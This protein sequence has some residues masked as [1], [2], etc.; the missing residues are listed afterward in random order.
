[1]TSLQATIV[2]EK[3]VVSAHRTALDG[4][5][6]RRPSSILCLCKSTSSLPRLPLQPKDDPGQSATTLTRMRIDPQRDSKLRRCR[7]APTFRNKARMFAQRRIPAGQQVVGGTVKPVPSAARWPGEPPYVA[8]P[9][10]AFSGGQGQVS[11]A[12]FPHAACAAAGSAKPQPLAPPHKTRRRFRSVTTHLTGE[13]TSEGREG[14]QVRPQIA[15]LDDSDQEPFRISL[16]RAASS[17]TP[18][19]SPETAHTYRPSCLRIVTLS[20]RS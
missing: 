12:I 8:T 15:I 14:S 5:S 2:S 3:E 9:E 20:S 6:Q 11:E 4:C 10:Y 1:M 17:R 18:P 19:R 16:R 7:P 13:G